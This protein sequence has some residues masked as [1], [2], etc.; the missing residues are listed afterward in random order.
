MVAADAAVLPFVQAGHVQQ[1]QSPIFLEL[2][3]RTSVN[4]E[5]IREVRLSNTSAL[6]IKGT[7]AQCVCHAD[8][9]T[10][11]SH[12][13]PERRLASL[14]QGYCKR[15]RRQIFSVIIIVTLGTLGL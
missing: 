8:H 5:A 4:S 1:T 12:G 10:S 11:F 2:S 6:W 13:L 7:P 15:G 9:T 3:D 14:T